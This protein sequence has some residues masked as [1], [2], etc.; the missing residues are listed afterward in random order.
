MLVM[1]ISIITFF[2]HIPASAAVKKTVIPQVA[3]ANAPV[4]Q[5]KAGDRV[6]FNIYAPNYGG[7]VEYRVVLWNDSMKTY[8]DL[9]DSSNG[10]PTRYY[11]KWQPY[12]N[13]IFTLGWIIQEPGTYRITV[14]AKRV[15]IAP[16]KAA[17]KGMNCDSYKESVAFVVK[18]NVATVQSLEALQDV[19]VN[20]GGT[21]V[22]PSTVNALMSDSIIKPLKV[23]WGTV[24]TTKPGTYTLQGTVEGTSLKASLRLI[25]NPVVTALNVNSVEA[26]SQI[27]I[28]INLNEI[29]SY[30]PEI[31]RFSLK[32]YYNASLRVYS[33]IISPD[34][35]VIQLSTDTLTKGSYYIL[36]IDNREYTF[37]VP[38]TVP[39]TSSGFK[40]SLTAK[41][42]TVKVNASISPDI[43][44]FPADANLSIT[45][46]NPNIARYDSYYK[47]IV[48]VAPGTTT[49]YVSAEKTGYS[50]ASTSFNVQ[51]TGAP[52]LVASP[53]VL[54]ESPENNGGLSTRTISVNLVNDYFRNDINISG[55]VI[56]YNLPQGM[57]YTVT[58]NSSTNLTVYIS[59]NATYHTETDDKNINI[60]AY[61]VLSS[62]TEYLVSN[63]VLLD[64]KDITERII[65]VVSEVTGKTVKYGTSFAGLE[66]PN[67]VRVILDNF[68][69]QNVEVAWDSADYK[70]NK[71]GTYEIDGILVNLPAGIKNPDNLKA[72]ISVTVEEKKITSVSASVKTVRIGT[73]FEA[74]QLPATVEATMDDG[75]KQSV[76]VTWI[77]SGY[78]NSKVGENTIEGTLEPLP[79][80][81]NND[82]NKKATIKIIVENN[83][84]SVKPVDNVTVNFGTEPG[85]LGLP[86]KVTVILEDNSEIEVTVTWNTSGFNGEE[87]KTYTIEGVLGGFPAGVT[88]KN[89]IKASIT[90]I[91]KPQQLGV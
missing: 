60:V 45:S 56:V 15:G 38:N 22:L 31:T 63:E 79:D 42:M 66:L 24:D 68:T 17:L 40:V 43:T 7:R 70:V 83:V 18:P 71:I 36:K 67:T 14:Y 13:N 77:N 57:S 1:L 25:V 62:G 86:N 87:P 90:V 28:N 50:T 12:G 48:G 30:T 29:L 59:G 51:V 33:M 73:T 37:Q 58:K 9:W 41:D 6:G 4:T 35:R 89:G 65:K 26:S 21:A 20:Q 5:Y 85:Q 72:K 47:K 54:T 11:T 88:N 84:I 75:S 80:G 82:D 81:V 76:G 10:Y 61:N 27:S 78:D 19:T 55:N 2:S 23:T 49:F 74:L 8:Y 53:S 64:F 69:T 46:Y 91:V 34:K 32:S 39:A 52:S 3:F 16:S 44:L